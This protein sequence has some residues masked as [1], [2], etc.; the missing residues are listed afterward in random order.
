MLND[1]LFF[2]SIRQSLFGSTMTQSQV[3]GIN[4]LL[5]A[6]SP[7][8]RPQQAYILATA[9]HETART[10]QPVEE[11]G[12]GRGR[13]Y[14]T[15]YVNSK[16]V[17]YAYRNGRRNSVYT[18]DEYPHLYYGRG[19]IQLTWLTN[20]RRAGQE[21]HRLKLLDDPDALV[22]DP[23][24]A[25]RPDISAMILCLGMGQ[26]WFTGRKLKHYINGREHDFYNARRIV[27]GTDK[28]DLIA[29]HARKFLAALELIS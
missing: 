4:T 12:K 8:S 14:G 29:S 9:L 19:H 6:V 11:R 17:R 1:K 21:L 26:G 20:Y 22:R 25:L 15:W 23:D 3:D 16:G 13:T 18:Y 5:D 24:L 7:F 10:M 27:N 2:D 28:A